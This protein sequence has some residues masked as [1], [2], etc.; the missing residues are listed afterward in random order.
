MVS[1]IVVNTWRGLPFYGITLLAGLQTISPDLYEAAAIDGASARQRFWHVTLP[2]LKPVLIIVTM[3]SVIFTFSDFQLVYVLTDGGP[4]NATH[5]FATLRVRHRHAGGPARHGRG[6][7]A[8]D[9]AAARRLLIVALTLYLRRD[10]MVGGRGLRGRRS[11]PCGS[12]C[13]W[14][15]SW[16]RCCFPSTGW[17]SRRSSRT[18]SSTAPKIMPLIVHQPTLKH[19]VDLITQTSFLTWTY[20]TLLVAVVSTAVSLVLGT[21]IAYPLARMNF[22]GAAVVAIGVAATYLVPQPLLFI[23]MADIINRLNLG[24]TLTAV[25]LTY[26]TLLIPFSRLAAHGLLQERAARAGGGGAHRRGQP[27]AGHDARRAARSARRGCSRPGSS[28]SPWPRT[29]SSTR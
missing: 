22:P 19:Y 16:S 4:A 27:V 29:S 26:P 11:G 15:S 12:T 10:V 1:I 9:A 14:R 7:G 25:M 3:F 13:R 5:L 24:N 18:A 6:G 8:D 28:P 20:N 23:P 21:M 17:P 2:I